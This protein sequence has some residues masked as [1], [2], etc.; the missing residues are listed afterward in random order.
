M[1]VNGACEGKCDGIKYVVWHVW[2]FT[3]WETTLKQGLMGKG[4]WYYISWN[5]STHYPLLCHNLIL[6]A[7]A[8][9]EIML[10]G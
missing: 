6:A 9:G 1:T 7:W 10:R 4:I 5:S 8:A 3:W 2:R